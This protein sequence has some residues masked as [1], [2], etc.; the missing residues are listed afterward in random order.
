MDVNKARSMAKPAGRAGRYV[1]QPT[2]YRAFVPAPLPPDPPLRIDLTLWEWLSRADQAVGRL[3]GIASIVPNPNLFVAMYVR[4]EAVLS[5]QIEGTESSLDDVLTFE[6]DPRRRGLPGD[7]EEV[8]NYVRA[9]NYGLARLASLPLSLRLIREIHG[10]LMRNVR[11][12]EKQPGQFRTTQNWIGPAHA[13]LARAT[14]VPPAPGDMWR[15]LDDF[16]RFLH[17]TGGLPTLVHTAIAH[18]QFETI[19]PFLDGNRRVGRL[20][21]TL[22]LVHQGALR[23]PLLYLSYFLRRNRAEYYDRLTAIRE[24]DDWESWVRFFLRGVVETAEEATATARSILQ[25]RDEHRASIE[26]HGGGLNALRLLDLLFQRPIVDARLVANTLGVTF[27]T[28]IRIIRQ[29][30]VVGLIQEVTGGKRARK[31]RY[32]A[33]LRLFEEAD[34]LPPLNVPID[35][36]RM[37][38]DGGMP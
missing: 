35:V 26:A 34:E 3:D 10:E 29:L 24:A 6:L 11:G 5:S 14:F 28:A 18:A 23:L 31:Y 38:G 8:V 15:A 27:K 32:G 36:S 20:L 21:I 37:T 4:R 22:L 25:L 2:G 1:Q 7:V 19:H 16:E 33:Y 12:A 9:M 13:P 17:D 30:E